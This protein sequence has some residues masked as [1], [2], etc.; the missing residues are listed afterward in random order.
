MINAKM[1]SFKRFFNQGIWGNEELNYLKNKGLISDTE[2]KEIALKPRTMTQDPRVGRLQYEYEI[3]DKTSPINGVSAEKFIKDAGLEHA[4]EI[5]L[6]KLGNRIIEV[7]DVE[8]LRINHNISLSAQAEDVAELYTMHLEEV[9]NTP[10][11]D[12]EDVKTATIFMS[13]LKKQDELI[14]MKQLLS[15]IKEILSEKLESGV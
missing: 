1:E 6:V 11:V 9:R 12:I 8:T 14:E 2:I 4:D 5:V 10:Y 3:W 15:D 13:E 7:S